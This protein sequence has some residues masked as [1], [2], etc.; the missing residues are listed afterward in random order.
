MHAASIG[1]ASRTRA[2]GQ[3]TGHMR[4]G[5]EKPAPSLSQRAR[6]LEQSGTPSN[7]TSSIAATRVGAVRIRRA[8]G[9]PARAQAYHR[10]TNLS[11]H[12]ADGDTGTQSA[13]SSEPRFRHSRHAINV[14]AAV[15]GVFPHTRATLE[16]E[17]S[18]TGSECCKT[19]AATLL[20]EVTGVQTA[21]S[22]L[23]TTR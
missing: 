23:Q 16:Q 19:P 13:C 11:G 21:S 9:I 10:R 12:R 22:K 7:R 1:K 8:P 5:L 17:P 3:G 14:R 6:L 20:G 4:R 2:N 15:K 18:R